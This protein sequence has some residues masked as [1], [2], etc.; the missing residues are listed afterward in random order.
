M[1]REVSATLNSNSSGGS[2]A[3]PQWKVPFKPTDLLLMSSAELVSLDDFKQPSKHTWLLA[4]VTQVTEQAAEAAAS[5]KPATL[6]QAKEG[7]ASTVMFKLKV[8]AHPDSP[9]HKALAAAAAQSSTQA[10]HS[11]SSSSKS[12][13][14][15]CVR[16]LGNLATA[17]RTFDAL[18]QLG[19]QGSSPH[20]LLLELMQPAGMTTNNDS[21]SSQQDCRA[22]PAAAGVLSNSSSFPGDNSMPVVGGSLFASAV[23]SYCQSS[24][25]LNPSQQEVV[26]NIAESTLLRSCSPSYTTSTNST[27]SSGSDHRT[28]CS[29]SSSSVC[30]TTVSN[31]GSSSDSKAISLVQ[32]PPGTG[33]TATV[34]RLLSV[35]GCYGARVL[36]CAPTN[37]AVAE[38]TSR[39]LQL[40][41]AGCQFAQQ[42]GATNSAAAVAAPLASS[43]PGRRSPGGSGSVPGGGGGGYAG[44]LPNIDQ[45]ALGDVL[46]VGNEENL[47]LQGDLS[48]VY[49]PYRVKRLMGIAG[50]T[51]L[52][53]L[54]SK[55]LRH[56]LSG[57]LLVEFNMEEGKRIQDESYQGYA[58]V[59]SPSTNSIFE[60]GSSSNQQRSRC[61]RF[62]GLLMNRLQSLQQQLSNAREVIQQDL[63]YSMVADLP[64]KLQQVLILLQ[65]LLDQLQTASPE[66][67]SLS[68]SSSSESEPLALYTA[69]LEAP[70]T[71]SDISV[72]SSMG[73]QLQST[74]WL[75]T[76]VQLLQA[77]KVAAAALPKLLLP[78][79]NFYTLRRACLQGSRHVFCTV[80]MVGSRVMQE[81]GCF[82]VVVVDEAAQVVEAEIAIVVARICCHSM[83]KGDGRNSQ[84]EQQQQVETRSGNL[85]QLVLVGDPKQL[86]ATV[87]SQRAVSQGYSRSL[88]ER[89]QQRGSHD[90]LLLDEQYRC[91][92]EI[93]LW[94]RWG[95]RGGINLKGCNMEAASACLLSSTGSSFGT[96]TEVHLVG[97]KAVV[98]LQHRLDS[99][100][101]IIEF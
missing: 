31:A 94:P 49:L 35:L 19:L 16:I 67:Q 59:S 42:S 46:L 60:D 18:Q 57:Q 4:L 38:L 3:G 36:A 96:K 79:A 88:F 28:P 99:C 95:E 34:V 70:Y 24:P 13:S 91:R 80:S 56:T 101:S 47:D 90:V 83:H 43:C 93:S 27:S 39:Y 68:S 63:P 64:L 89:L 75:V 45:L 29:I 21:A 84:Q 58:A 23:A 32:G 65:R 66:H 14:S 8:F 100:V 22:R 26:V 10:S 92:P 33:K 78:H 69:L 97:L 76:A 20:P 41:S 73:G 2:A 71:L 55:G 1:Q 37:V 82:A 74:P 86:P 40:L 17:M 6:P 50:P 5:S 62:A 48:K 30:E 77:A 51:G 98:R 61:K 53:G 15:W 11:S 9:E 12:S 44:V 25:A 52:L 54:L 81:A 87:F 85:T 7:E 72:L